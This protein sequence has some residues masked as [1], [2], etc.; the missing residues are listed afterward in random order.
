MATFHSGGGGP[1]ARRRFW[2]LA[3]KEEDEAK[4]DKAIAMA[5]VHSPS[6]SDIIGEF[7]QDGS[8]EELAVDADAAVPTEVQASRG[9]PTDMVELAQRPVHRTTV[10]AAVRPWIGPILTYGYQN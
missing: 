7:F 1:T 10:A 3:E 5:E 8:D 6:T 9:S 4:D 2:V